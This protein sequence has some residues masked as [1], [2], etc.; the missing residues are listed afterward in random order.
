[1]LLL[2]LH[3]ILDVGC[4]SGGWILDV[5]HTYPDREATGIDICPTMVTYNQAQAM[6]Q[7]LHNVKFL[8]MDALRPLK[9]EIGTF[10]L[11]NIRFAVA[12]IPREKFGTLLQN[13]LRVLRPGGILRITEGESVGLTNNKAGEKMNSWAA[14]LLHMKGYGFSDDGSH[15]GILPV[16]GMLLQEAGC[17][18]IQSMPHILDYSMGTA[19]HDSQ[20]QNYMVWPQLIKTS[21]LTTLS[22]AEGEFDQTYRQ[23]LEEMQ[24]PRFCGLWSLL[25]VWGERSA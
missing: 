6:V 8:V 2:H 5:A 7:R 3:S 23:M 14:R 13:C 16:L 24:M 19:L 12:F 25:T 15:I 1:M 17:V 18:N 11:V 21:L 4:G 20:Y 10:D 22:I 9:F